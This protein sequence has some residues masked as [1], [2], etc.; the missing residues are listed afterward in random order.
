MNLEE[1]PDADTIVTELTLRDF[2]IESSFSEQAVVPLPVEPPVVPVLPDV[3]HLINRSDEVEY[4][5][6]YGCSERG[7]TLLCDSY[8][9]S[10]A[11]KKGT[12]RQPCKI[13]WRCSKRRGATVGE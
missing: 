7:E 12:Y 6:I 9:Y 13:Q 11:E 2:H 3:A 5:V 10:Y 8:G 4:E 1:G